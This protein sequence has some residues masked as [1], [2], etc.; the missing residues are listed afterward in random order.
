MAALPYYVQPDYVE[1]DYTTPHDGSVPE[2]PYY[3]QPGYNDG[4]Y[5]PSHDGSV[6]VI[7]TE[8]AGA[9]VVTAIGTPFAAI[10][11]SSAELDVS[12][13]PVSVNSVQ[14]SDVG[15]SG[16]SGAL[17]SVD[18]IPAEPFPGTKNIPILQMYR[19]ASSV[20]VASVSTVAGV[21]GV[22]SVSI[23][24]AA[25]SASGLGIA[26]QSPNIISAPVS[27]INVAESS[28]ASASSSPVGAQVNPL[29]ST[30]S[31]SV[32]DV[33]EPG[34]AVVDPIM[35]E[36]IGTS[37]PVVSVTGSAFAPLIAA[38]FGVHDGF[39]AVT[40]SSPTVNTVTETGLSAARSTSASRIAQPITTD[41]A[42]S[43]IGAGLV[44]ESVSSAIES[45]DSGSTSPVSAV[46]SASVDAIETGGRGV[47]FAD[48]SA[49]AA[50]G[51]PSDPDDSTVFID[52]PG[53]LASSTSSGIA[54][55]SS[56]ATGRVSIYVAQNAIRVN[57]DDAT[58]T[59][60]GDKRLIGA[61]ILDAPPNTES[62]GG[63][64]PVHVGVSPLVDVRNLPY[65]IFALYGNITIY[66]T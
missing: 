11:S 23:G 4:S 47:S 28:G 34:L 58:A 21:G 55:A 26:N 13:E 33:T 9:V 36:A 49:V 2:F 30:D 48:S 6:P 62:L 10:A 65:S 44:T 37:G 12:L 32:T 22:L 43:S 50:F 64:E 17:T 51:A 14:V 18:A 45:G 57:G 52:S 66:P 63:S 38:E 40:Q 60:P 24:S 59:D 42:A 7:V 15:L 31:S 39:P 29:P 5:T 1:A 61:V 35:S 53:L 25:L 41:D 20:A 16:I 27:P 3:V 8:N 46:Y 54:S 19:A 56:I